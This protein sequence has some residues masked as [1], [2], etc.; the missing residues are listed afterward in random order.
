[1]NKGDYAPMTPREHAD[2]LQEAYRKMDQLRRERDRNYGI[3]PATPEPAETEQEENLV[4]LEE[5]EKPPIQEKYTEISCLVCAKQ[6]TKFEV[7]STLD[8][9][10]WEH[11]AMCKPCQM[12]FSSQNIWGRKG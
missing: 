8:H 12:T 7:A 1:M 6:L 2:A 11:G 4:C 3:E 5:E 10:H 9:A